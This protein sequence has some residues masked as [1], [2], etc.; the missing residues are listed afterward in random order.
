MSAKWKR[1]QSRPSTF[2]IKIIVKALRK[3]RRLPVGLDA[4]WRRRDPCLK[5]R[6]LG[7]QLIGTVATTTGNS[8][9]SAQENDQED[10]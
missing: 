8:G 5:C 6:N 1:G 2:T 4:G 3:H 10:Q 9:C 7:L